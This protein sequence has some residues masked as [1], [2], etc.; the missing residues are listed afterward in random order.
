MK[1]RLAKPSDLDA[2]VGII[3]KTF[4]KA[5]ARE[6][7]AEISGIMKSRNRW[8]FVL[9]VEGREVIGLAG[10][11]QS[12]LDFNLYEVFWVA[13]RPDFQKGGIGRLIMEDLVARARKAKGLSKAASLLVST[14]S[15]AFFA[16]CGFQ[17]L[18]SIPGSPCRL[19]SLKLG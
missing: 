5:D 13:V 2:M 1:L 7:R 8:F 9:A 10:L 11:I 18:D 17:A 19:M 3:A 4:P 12:W 6:A 15:P 14:D 16:K